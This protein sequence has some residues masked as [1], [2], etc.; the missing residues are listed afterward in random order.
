LKIAIDARLL[1]GISGGVQQWVIGIAGALSRLTD[2]N[3]EYLFLVTR[4]YGAWLEP[5]LSGRCRTLVVPDLLMDTARGATVRGRLA[6]HLPLAAALWRS[7]R[8]RLAQHLPAPA[9]PTSDGEVEA[10]DVDVV[11]FTFQSAFLTAIPSVYQPWDLQHR[12]LPSFF[13][14]AE[15]RNRERTYRAFSDQ[16]RVVLAATTW[17]KNDLVAELGIAPG[18]IAVVNVPPVTVLYPL[19]SPTDMAEIGRKFDLPPRYVFYPAQAWPHKNHVRLIRALARLRDEAGLQVNLV[20]SGNRG[21][22]FRSVQRESARLGLAS[23]VRFVGFVTPMELQ[24]LYRSAR[25]L[26]FPSLYEGWGLPIVEAF[27]AGLP[28]AC[29]NTTSLPAL[30]GDAAIVFD[31]MDVDDIAAA[32]RR[33]WDDDDLGREL[34][35]RGRQRAAQMDWTVVARTLRALYR[36]AAG[37]ATTEADAA[38]LSLSPLV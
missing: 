21:P 28:V 11:H 16:A 36:L 7:G 15:R 31:P 32:I 20:C 38:L 3:E 29:S 4:G 22:G 12:H 24:V 2:G 25:A 23:Q 19:P 9:L 8:D 5:Y 18:K 34:A 27:Q 26:V 13:S 10:A 35:S 1:D 17:V 37:R 6:E 14:A 33:V 30:V